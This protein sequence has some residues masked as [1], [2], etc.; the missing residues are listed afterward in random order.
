MNPL[1]STIVPEGFRYR[2]V[3]RRGKPV[4]EKYDSFSLR[5]PSMPLEKRA[6]IFSPFDALKGFG[7]AI[8][9]KEILPEHRRTLS[10][11]DLR[12][13][14]QKLDLLRQLT[15]SSGSPRPEPV[16][17]EICFFSAL[18]GSDDPEPAGIYRTERGNLRK[19]DDFARMLILDDDTAIPADDIVSINSPVLDPLLPD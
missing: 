17:V 5:H 7:E 16:P 13:L 4:H 18:A 14:D 10:E 2:E 6:K 3:F 19:V 11:E 8:A 15:I 12:I 9:S 1:N